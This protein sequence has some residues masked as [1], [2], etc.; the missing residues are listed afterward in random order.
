FD[1]FTV[2]ANCYIYI[3]SS[4]S[5]DGPTARNRIINTGHRCNPVR[6]AAILRVAHKRIVVRIGQSI[7]GRTKVEIPEVR[8]TRNAADRGDVAVAE[9]VAANARLDILADVRCTCRVVST[10]RHPP[11]D[12]IG[13]AGTWQRYWTAS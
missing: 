2:E 4:V 1:R 7:H 10:E 12:V 8:A 3:T 11:M 6:L 9:L 13:T 5:P